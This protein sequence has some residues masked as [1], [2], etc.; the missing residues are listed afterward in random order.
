MAQRAMI[1]NS[2]N[3]NGKNAKKD[4]DICAK[5]ISASS[6]GGE[7]ATSGKGDLIDVDES[8]TRRRARCSWRRFV[9]QQVAGR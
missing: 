2:K 1:S 7:S 8:T 6:G 3:G 4:A 9:R 5:N